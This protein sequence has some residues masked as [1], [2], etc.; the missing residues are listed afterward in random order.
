MIHKLSV[1]LV[2]NPYGNQFLNV[3]NTVINSNDEVTFDTAAQKIDAM[4]TK[5]MLGEKQI[6]Y[7]ENCISDAEVSKKK[8]LA[9]CTRNICEF[10]PI[11]YS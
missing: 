11:F 5:Q 3:H 1:L 2:Q 8:F 7:V 6:Q 9:S 4:F 10:W